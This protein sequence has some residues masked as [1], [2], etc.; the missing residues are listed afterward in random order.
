[1][2]AVK[3]A[4]GVCVLGSLLFDGA[5]AF[6]ATSPVGGV[7]KVW[8][9]PIGNGARGTAVITGAIGDH[10]TYVDVNA[11][12]KT[13]KNG[14]YT[15]VILKKGTILFDSTQL[16]AAANAAFNAQPSDYNAATCSAS[17]VVS[18][19]NPV[20]SGTKAYARITGSVTITATIAFIGPLTK[21]GACNTSS[22]ANPVALYQ[23]IVG[24]GTVAFG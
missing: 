8:A 3:T 14:N 17:I 20:V 5:S 23:S 6:G 11:A 19:P 9:T 22:N 12:G 18:A 7:V 10:G 1:M 16:N 4:L 2:R 21:S 15:K 13:D 24:S